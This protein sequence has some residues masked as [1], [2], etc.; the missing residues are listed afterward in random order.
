[1]HR[2]CQLQQLNPVKCPLNMAHYITVHSIVCACC[3][4]PRAHTQKRRRRV[5]PLEW[6]YKKWF[7][8]YK[9]LSAYLDGMRVRNDDP[10]L[11]SK[12]FKYTYN[13][14]EM[15]HEIVGLSGFFSCSLP[16]AS[17][18]A[19]VAHIAKAIAFSPFVRITHIHTFPNIICITSIS[20]DLVFF[21][22]QRNTDSNGDEHVA[23]AQTMQNIHK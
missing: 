19:A 8:G 9:T 7:A 22:S 1:M 6:K 12:Y 10:N 2:Q 18:I 20:F 23:H 3:V 16:L 11:K 4:Q 21:R 5:R 14:W 13:S 15:L 17:I